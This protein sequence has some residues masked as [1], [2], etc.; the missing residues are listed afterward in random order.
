MA[1]LAYTYSTATVYIQFAD[2]YNTTDEENVQ[3]YALGT[4]ISF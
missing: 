1:K 3:S 2:D 4:T